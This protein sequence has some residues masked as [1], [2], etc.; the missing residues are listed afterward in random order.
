MS[1]CHGTRAARPI[2]REG[3]RKAQEPRNK[4]ATTT[5]YPPSKVLP[6]VC[7]AF[8]ITQAGHPRSASCIQSSSS[9]RHRPFHTGIMAKASGREAVIERRP[10]NQQRTRR[11]QEHSEHR[12]GSGEGPAPQREKQVWAGATAPVR[13]GRSRERAPERPKSLGT[14]QEASPHTSTPAR[15]RSEGRQRGKREATDVVPG[16]RGMKPMNE[17]GKRAMKLRERQKA[18]QIEGGG[19]PS[20]ECGGHDGRP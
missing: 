15:P 10:H 19:D 18:T 16:L 14:E 8:S 6:P 7:E 13:Q 5:V 3:T 1:R 9:T 4:R 17:R 20:R 2:K 11:L 12:P